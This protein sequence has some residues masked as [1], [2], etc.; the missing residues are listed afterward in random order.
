MKVI[1][2]Q[3][4]AKLG[5]RFSEVTVPDGH[6]LNFLIPK[7]MAEG[8][9]PQNRKKLA[10]QIANQTASQ[11]A[12]DE[13]LKLAAV[14]FTESPLIIEAEANEQDHLFQAV[15][16]EM[17]VAAAAKRSIM[18]D[19]GQVHPTEPIKSLGEHKVTIGTPSADT[20]I[21]ISVVKKS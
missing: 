4:V 21:T 5:R 15:K 14:T 9:T 1:L 20:V 13:A 12:D 8:A 17:I 19:A 11:A 3:D 18:L 16:P 2:L 10:A 6:A 7:G